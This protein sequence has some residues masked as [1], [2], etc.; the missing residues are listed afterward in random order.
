MQLKPATDFQP[1]E[2]ESRRRQIQTQ[3]CY[4]LAALVC[5]KL[6]GVITMQG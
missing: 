1:R 4:G 2:R 6:G 5:F 3:G